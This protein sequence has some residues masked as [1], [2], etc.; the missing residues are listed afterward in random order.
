MFASLS[1][2]E[3]VVLLGAITAVAIISNYLRLPMIVAFILGG[4]AAGPYGF[5]L[6][7]SIP[8]AGL[9]AEIAAIFLMFTIGLEF[10]F[11]KL[12]DLKR[13]FLK[14]GFSQVSL[15]ICSMYLSSTELYRQLHIPV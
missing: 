7:E 14:L 2:L 3:F 15:S 4:V 10:S 13:E 8:D 1:F 5:K 9:M 11:R 6:V 12:K